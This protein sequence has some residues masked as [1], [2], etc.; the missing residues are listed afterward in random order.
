MWAR[1]GRL[2][3]PHRLQLWK[4]RYIDYFNGYRHAYGVADFEH[5]DAYVDSETGK[6]ETSIQMELRRTN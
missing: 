2:S 4:K 5:P 6:K 1:I 3:G